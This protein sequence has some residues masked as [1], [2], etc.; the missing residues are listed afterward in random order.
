[1][2]V[3]NRHQSVGN[4]SNRKT[5]SMDKA[6]YGESKETLESERVPN[7][8]V[9]ESEIVAQVQEKVAEANLEDVR[10]TKRA[11]FSAL[12]KARKLEST[13]KEKL[14]KAE[15]IAAAHQ[16][17]DLDQI[18]KAHDMSTTDYVRWVNAKAIGAPTEKTPTPAE[19]VAANAK[20]WQEKID[21]DVQELKIAKN[22]NDKMSYI[23]KNILPH[24]IKSPE[25]YEFIHDK[26]IDQV[27]DIV[28]DFM[29]QHFLETGEEL[30]PVE[31][32]KSLED[33]YCEDFRQDLKIKEEKKL[34]FKKLSTPTETKTESTP[35]GPAKTIGAARSVSHP[36]VSEA[37]I[38][39]GINGGAIDEDAL[40]KKAPS[41]LVA[42]AS[43]GNAPAIKQPI[44]TGGTTPK[45]SK[46]SREA[47]LAALAKSRE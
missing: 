22:V 30:D 3:I 38:L 46:Y 2:P 43:R 14:R 12:E 24:L 5:Y 29:N 41:N 39:S 33:Q 26:G 27:S 35:T 34:K 9:K 25:E 4:I 32:I 20:K 45:S 37:D 28:Y 31:L 17:G 13:A 42:G 1:M 36:T 8:E 10:A 11:E 6:S 19:Q 40:A 44:I 16:S 21:K 7:T 47:R 18:A 23:N 15:S